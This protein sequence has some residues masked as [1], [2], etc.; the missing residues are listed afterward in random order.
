MGSK[1]NYSGQEIS[2]FIF[3]DFIADR[4]FL[5]VDETLKQYDMLVNNGL[6]AKISGVGSPYAISLNEYKVASLFMINHNKKL[7]KSLKKTEEDEYGADI[8]IAGDHPEIN[9]LGESGLDY[10]V[11]Y[12]VLGKIE[13]NNYA[14]LNVYEDSDESWYINFDLY[15]IGKKW[16]KYKDEYF[17]L[18]DHFKNL[19]K[20]NAQ[21][22]ISFTDGSPVKET[23]FKS[24]D[25]MI[26][27]GKEEEIKYI[28]NWVNNIPKFY[29]YGITPKLSILLYGEPGTGKS[30]FYKA[31]A[32]HLGIDRIQS[33][34]PSFF[35]DDDNNKQKNGRG[36]YSKF[37][38]CV[39]ALDDID[40]FCASREENESKENSYITHALLNYLDTPDTFYFKAKD[41]IYYPVSI[42]VATT[43]YYDK[44]DKAVKR[45]GRFDRKIEMKE[46]NEKQARDMCAI[47]GLTLENVLPEKI[48][49]DKEFIISPSYLQSLCTDKIDSDLKSN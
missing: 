42:I 4:E 22:Y 38:G 43:N 18:L 12:A 16:K 13:R 32:K 49:I 26:F 39:L 17:K 23:T 44:L 37:R 45:Y 47:Y 2:D 34:S 48:K 14:V 40:C 6:G 7:K 3:E 8:K 5:N 21:E 41:G 20:Q 15:I 10:G 33:I 9:K 30:T 35:L 36:Y 31:L 27:E 29:Q 24:F 1:K 19:Q 46:F 25:Q 11:H 28:D